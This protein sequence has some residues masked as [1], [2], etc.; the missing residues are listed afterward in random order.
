ME[1]SKYI[2]VNTRMLVK[3]GHKMDRRMVGIQPHPA[4]TQMVNKG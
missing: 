2:Q 4:G 1:E 3:K